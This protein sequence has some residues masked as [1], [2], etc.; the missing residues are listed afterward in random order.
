MPPPPFKFVLKMERAFTP[1]K[2]IF[3]CSL[4]L[5]ASAMKTFFQIEPTDLAQKLDEERVLG[6]GGV[7]TIPID[8]FYLFF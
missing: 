3:S 8:Y 5:G 7:A 2:Q 1:N 4:I 6:G